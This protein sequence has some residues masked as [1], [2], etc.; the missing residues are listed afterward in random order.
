MSWEAHHCVEFD[1]DG[2]PSA[3]FWL[4]IVSVKDLYL[5][6]NVDF[7]K[8]LVQALIAGGR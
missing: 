5:K 2:S 8:Q 3:I 6:L 4:H 1:L 7:P